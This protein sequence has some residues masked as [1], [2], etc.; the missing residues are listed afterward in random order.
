MIIRPSLEHGQESIEVPTFLFSLE[1]FVLNGVVEK[2][3]CD[4][5]KEMCCNLEMSF[6]YVWL[7]LFTTGAD[8][9]YIIALKEFMKKTVAAYDARHHRYAPPCGEYN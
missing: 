4:F 9:N 2:C 8:E 1:K 3:K 6:R 7:R 5:E